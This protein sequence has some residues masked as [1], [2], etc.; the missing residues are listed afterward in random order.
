MSEPKLFEPDTY[1]VVE[2]LGHQTFAG[3]VSEHVVGG[4]AFIRV[5]VPEMPESRTETYRG[6]NVS[7]KIPGFTKL[8]GAGSIYAITPCSEQVAMKVAAQRRSVPV[9][10]VELEPRHVRTQALTS[11]IED[12]VDV[13]SG[14]AVV[15]DHCVKCGQSQAECVCDDGCPF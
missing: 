9:S 5:D 1:A 10:I 3:K 12:R 15:D 8:I 4:T 11:A 2:V 13:E 7:P 6:E 14:S